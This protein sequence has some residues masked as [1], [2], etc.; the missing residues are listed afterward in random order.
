MSVK[1][2]KQT[3]ALNNVASSTSSVTV[4]AASATANRRYVFNDSSANLYLAYTST[5]A[6]TS[7]FTVKLATAT[8]ILIEDYAGQV[9][10]IWDAANGFAR[11]TEW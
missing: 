9:T 1:P 11:T 6:S 2:Q 4:F 3:S 8:G 10:G 7:N 5:A